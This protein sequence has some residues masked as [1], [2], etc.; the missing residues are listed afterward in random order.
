[1]LHEDALRLAESSGPA[2]VAAL[3]RRAQAAR[4]EPAREP[5][6]PPAPQM[7]APASPPPPTSENDRWE[8]IELAPGVELHVREAAQAPQRGLIARLLRAAGIRR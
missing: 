8:R 6:P 4:P 1:M 7:S 3:L 5:V 2:Y